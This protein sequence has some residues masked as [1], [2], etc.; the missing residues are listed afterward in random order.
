M[1]RP[2]I[3][4]EGYH[5]IW[6]NSGMCLVLEKAPPGQE[7]KGLR[8]IKVQYHHYEWIE[9]AVEEDIDWLQKWKEAV[10]N[11]DTEDSYQDWKDDNLSDIVSDYSSDYEP[12][13]EM[14]E[15]NL[16]KRLREHWWSELYYEAQLEVNDEYTIASY[17]EL[18]KALDEDWVCVDDLDWELLLEINLYFNN[19]TYRFVP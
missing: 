7:K 10:A 6:Y 5:F 1:A 16:Y 2:E 13:W 11:D 15:Y 12:S 9:E 3:V 14:P 17:E 8:L 18:M 4:W 19:T